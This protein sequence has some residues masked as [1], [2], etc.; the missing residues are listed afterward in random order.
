MIEGKPYFVYDIVSEPT[1]NDRGSWDTVVSVSYDDG[2][3][4][5]DKVITLATP[6]AVAVLKHLMENKPE[7]VTQNLESITERLTFLKSVVTSLE[8]DQALFQKMRETGDY[9]LVF[10]DTDDSEDEDD[11]EQDEVAGVEYADLDEV[12][13]PVSPTEA[14]SNV[15]DL[16]AFRVNKSRPN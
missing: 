16:A 4:V 9:F 11:D 6:E 5:E 3:T 12:D 13:I 14:D 7:I 8:K 10:A 2:A 1:Q 15:F